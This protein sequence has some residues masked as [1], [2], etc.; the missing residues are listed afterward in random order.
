MNEILTESVAEDV[1]RKAAQQEMREKCGIGQ[2]YDPPIPA[3]AIK[4]SLD[5]MVAKNLRGVRLEME[6][7][8][9]RLR[10]DILSL[11]AL[12]FLMALTG[13][14]LAYVHAYVGASIAIMTTLIPGLGI[15]TKCDRRAAILRRLD[16]RK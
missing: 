8:A 13:G 12:V 10:I 9:E 7:R 2:H 16:A 14:I 11:T 6:L 3:S 4:K 15:L 1:A 5:A